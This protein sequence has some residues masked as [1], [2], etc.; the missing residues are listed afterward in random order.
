MICLG[1][2]LF[3]GGILP[4]KRSSRLGSLA[5]TLVV[6][7]LILGMLVVAAGA[8]LFQVNLGRQ[9]QAREGSR[10]LAES[11]AQVM[12]AR[13]IKD[14]NLSA[15]ST[16]DGGNFPIRLSLPSYPGGEGLATLHPTTA[17]A[18]GIPVSVN[19]LLQSGATSG[20]GT[21]NVAP[22][23][24]N[25]VGV[26]KYRGS[27]ARVEVILYLP[28]FPYVVSSSVPL[29][30]DGLE[31]FAVDDP[32][33]LDSGF[34]PT[35]DQRRPGHI[36][37]NAVDAAGVAAMVLGGGSLIQGDAQSRGTVD[38]QSATITGEI[39]NYADVAPIPS[40]TLS[41]FDPATMPGTTPNP[42]P[43]SLAGGTP[44]SGFHRSSGPLS[45]TGSLQLSGGFVFVDGA[46]TVSGGI[47]GN[48][49]LIATGPVTISGGGSALSGA[50]GAA[51][52]SGG[53]VSITGT[54]PA[55]RQ[56]FRG[57]IYTE[58]DLTTRNV[59]VAGA[60]AVNKP[61][62]AGAASFYQSTLVES[63]QLGVVQVPVTRTLPGTPAGMASL[64]PTFH[65]SIQG[66]NYFNLAPVTQVVGSG[67]G[68]ANVV[69]TANMNGPREDYTTPPPGF[70]ITHRPTAAEPYY[71]I[72]LPATMPADPTSL[73]SIRINNLNPSGPCDSVDADGNGWQSAYAGD[74]TDRASAASALIQ[75][76]QDWGA[77][78]PVGM[79][80]QFLDDALQDYVN[81]KLPL[82]VTAWNNNAR[83]LGTAG[84]TTTYVPGSPSITIPSVVTLDFSRFYN[85]SDRIKV[86]SW[87]EI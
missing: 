47:E 79:T 37:T 23:T 77:S 70:D 67:P 87:R 3:S 8:S 65:A 11:A 26:G 21:T 63:R 34:N 30:G 39:R 24:A 66:N 71:Q 51:I 84:P 76:A 13:L 31:V 56:Q 25:I 80:N 60:V 68:T 57:L 38:P 29:Q 72:A 55:D 52:L 81:N 7:V 6:L 35:P 33:V 2:N 5:N 41:D 10:A 45:V 75:A 48:G 15:T 16:L 44:L 69:M 74:F 64:P 85:L 20:W 61:G 40:I 1:A 86:L 32:S 9:E 19:N 50:N 4:R 27:E 12:M 42:L 53:D 49:A 17:A 22:E 36:A 59:N 43:P 62:G 14:P 58:G 73:G 82:I 18:L 46:V 54:A 83:L 28:K 78:D